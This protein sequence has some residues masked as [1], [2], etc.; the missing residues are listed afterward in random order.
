VVSP[1]AAE[2]IVG[3]TLQLAALVTDALGNRRDDPVS[4]NVS[5][6]SGSV[7]SSGRFQALA[8]GDGLVI[9]T[10]GSLADTA[11]VAVSDP[12]ASVQ[13]T[14]LAVAPTRLLPG[15]PVDEVAA[16][17][18][19]NPSSHADTL[20]VLEL[21]DVS[22]G[23]PGPAESGASWR[24]FELRDSL[25]VRLATGLWD[26]GRVRF[27]NIALPIPSGVARR[28]GVF[29]AASVRARDGDSLG[30]AVQDAHAVGMRSGRPVALVPGVNPARRVVDGM[31]AAQ[32]ALKSLADG[33][34]VAGS[35]RRLLASLRVPANGW[36]PDRL[37]RFDI[38]N[39]GT[40]TPG[41]DLEQLEA[42]LDD[43]NEQL[44]TLAD[45]RL[46]SLPFTGDRWQIT[47][48]SVDVPVGGVNVLLTVDVADGA[49]DGRTVRLALPTLPDEGVGMA[50]G[51]SGP[52]DREVL[53]DEHLIGGGE[54]VLVSA[55]SLPS[56]ITHAG[57]AS[58]PVLDLV[59]AN[60]TADTRR[61]RSLALTNATTGPGTTA[62]LD[63]EFSRLVLSQISDAASDETGTAAVVAVGGFVNGRALF[64]GLDLPVP[65]SRDIRLRITADVAP[66]SARDGD[67]LA[68]SLA[69]PQDI[70]FHEATTV[71]GTWPAHAGGEWVVDGFVASEVALRQVSGLTLAPLD[72]PLA[73][74]D[75]TLPGNGYL[76]DRLHGVRVENRGNADPA[77]IGELRLIRDG[78]D[79]RLAGAPSDDV[80]LGPLVPVAGA[81]QS[82]YLDEPIPVAGARFFVALTVAGA[83]SD[84]STV[85]LAIPAGGVE[86]ESG[87]DG[88]LDA[89]IANAE[90]HVLSTRPLL[91]SLTLEPSSSTIGQQVDVR[92]QVR[93]VGTEALDGVTPVA[94]AAEGTADHQWLSGPT[95]GPT[96]LAPGESVTFTWTV[97]PTTAGALRFVANAHGTGDPSGLERW[98]LVARTNTHP[99]FTEADS[100]RLLAQQSMPSAVTLGQTGVVPVT[101]TL[102]HP[103]DAS[104]SD[105]LFRRLRVR[106]E[107]EDGSPIVPAQ[108]ASAIE[109]REGTSVYLRRTSLETAG[110]LIDLT[111]DTPVALRPDDPVSLAVRLDIAGSTPIS[112]FR[113]VVDDSTGFAASDAISD[114]PVSVRLTG[115]AYPIRSGLARLLTGGGALVG[116][117]GT[118]APR[119]A[120]SGQ[121]AVALATWLLAHS[122]TNPTSADLRLNSI[123][124][125]PGSPDGLAPPLPWL[126]WRA[127]A[128]GLVVARHDASASDT[129]AVRLDLVPAPIVQPGAAV[130]LRLEADLTPA[131]AGVRFALDAVQPAQWDVRDVNS[132]DPAPVVAP[133]VLPG[134]TIV[135]QAPPAGLA[136]APDALLPPQVAAGRARQGALRLLLQHTGDP[137][138]AGV[139]LD[140]V[141]VALH[142]PDGSVVPMDDYLT[143]VRLVRRGAPLVGSTAPS[144]S[145]LTLAPALSVAGGAADTLTVEVDVAADAP[146]GSIELRVAG[147]SIHASD[148]NT[149][150]EVAVTPG[151]P[152]TWPF[153]SGV[154]AIVAPARELRVQLRDALPPLVASG[155]VRV[156]VGSLVL[157]HPGPASSGPIAVDHVDVR[158]SDAGGTALAVDAVASA[159]EAR[160]DAALVAGTGPL[161]AG[162]ARATLTFDPPLEIAAADSLV[163]E[164]S[165]FP[166][167]ADPVGRFRFGWDAADIGVVQPASALLSVAV[168]AAAGASFPMWTGAASWASAS[169]EE[170]VMNFPNPFAAGRDATTFA[171]LM[172]GPG[173]ATL[174]IWTARGEP[175]ITLLD[176]AS[177]PAGLRQSDRWDGRNGRGDV[178][179]NGVYVAEL[180]V[181]LDDGRSER[182][183][184]RVAVVR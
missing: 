34:L 118:P 27:E 136:V 122:S 111:L 128:N 178:V 106:L 180:D 46:G 14:T 26:S 59:V 167:A 108:L 38:A 141:R 130:T 1:E 81:W 177:L 45:Q 138:Q 147:A 164:V 43:G 131:S 70:G 103:G 112:S 55:P 32:V 13:L 40:G 61:L 154:A 89:P 39:R 6:P 148:A 155:G 115:Q 151:P 113:L 90:A 35:R 30:V 47:G 62:Q 84:S 15:A 8:A 104:S 51:N 79:G 42:W 175:V 153:G 87:H 158:A 162:T 19:G 29:G 95:P 169:F 149:R 116:S 127:V 57:D 58:V 50:G 120:T 94:P 182:V 172:P 110:D 23:P 25:G 93:N 56:G 72:G 21:D 101:L 28:V 83:T 184:R 63:G 68:V 173:R 145:A 157:H 17:R 170:S 31:T 85:R 49:R 88:P 10:S 161:A 144:A 183:L 150:A 146:A 139:V 54:R 71:A 142:A 44:D 24:T 48:L 92:M 5:G 82:A 77:E 105:I 137:T 179:T 99:V 78:G 143:A 16:L 12:G 66:A 64:D 109:V 11:L 159:V 166:R 41:L 60:G 176:A 18:L 67:R 121:S 160:R 117:S 100:L 129:G 174:R 96:R 74:L 53:A 4:W 75:V 2:L 69:S 76:A 156:A 3:D 37:L 152:A 114:R 9:A 165:V 168:L 20:D 135:V 171:F 119:T 124:V 33:P 102:E 132:G 107:Q 163:L 91:A 22:V 86:M 73:A 140:S 134:D 126:R 7:N 80:D 52:I 36:A 97:M 133:P 98:S 181:R 65:S 123:V 125:R